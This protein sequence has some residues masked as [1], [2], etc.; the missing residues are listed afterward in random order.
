MAKE[1]KSKRFFRP[2]DII[3]FEKLE[4]ESQRFLFLGFLVAVAFHAALGA[5]FM[6]RRSEVHVVKPLTMELVIRQPRMTK[7]FEFRKKRIKSRVYTKMA[8]TQRKPPPIVF[9][10]KIVLPG[11]PGTV[12]LYD[13]EPELKIEEGAAVSLPEIIDI[14]IKATR[15]PDKTISMKEELITVDDL[16]IGKYKGMVIKDP[17]DKQNIKGFVYIATLWGYDFVPQYKRGI[18]HLS[19][20]V[21][22]YTKIESK[23]DKHLLIDSREL[24]RTPFVY[25]CV[26]EGFELNEIEAR[27]FGEYL[28]SGGFAVF[29]NGLPMRQWNPAEPALRQAFRDALGQDAR[30]LPIPVNHPL[31]HCFYDFD[32]GPPQGSEIGYDYEFYKKYIGGWGYS[33]A[34]SD[35]VFFLEGIFIKDRLVAIYSDKGYAIKWA[36]DENNEPQLRM[37]VNMVVFALTQVGSIA[38][39]KI[40]MFTDRQ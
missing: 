23:V 38:E 27:N 16:D 18:L 26:D 7:P 6:Y 20:A 8:I 15:E 9:R 2:S 5:Y 35:P 13:F 4:R 39:Q 12:P 22:T 34:F 36:D 10:E 37:G 31:Y 11:F 1:F 30:F 32:D 25:L 24:F 40:E 28:R 29:D 14:E 21:N 19:D 3:D 17:T 33:Q